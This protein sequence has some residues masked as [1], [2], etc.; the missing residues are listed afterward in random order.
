MVKLKSKWLFVVA[1]LVFA[2]AVAG[3]QAS[4]SPVKKV[5]QQI[6][7]SY[8]VKVGPSVLPAG[9]YE[10]SSNDQGLTFRRMEQDVAYPGQW[11]YAMKEKPVVVKCTVTVLDAKSR[12]TQ[13]EMPAD[14]SGVR[15]LKAITL[16]DTNVKFTITQ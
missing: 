9:R 2:S 13:M 8:E 11:N 12:G 6:T 3:A 16:D 1:G 15:V 10:V 14:T 7:F 4:Q 5:R